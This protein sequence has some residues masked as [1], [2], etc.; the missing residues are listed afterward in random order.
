MAHG[1]PR[2]KTSHGDGRGTMIH[3]IIMIIGLY[4]ETI[5]VGLILGM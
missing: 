4:F 1:E 3:G 5:N 2:I